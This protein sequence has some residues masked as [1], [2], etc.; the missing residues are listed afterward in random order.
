MSLLK[1]ITFVLVVVFW[2]GKEF[3][4]T[5]LN[6]IITYHTLGKYMRTTKV[7]GL[8]DLSFL[9]PPLPP[10]SLLPSLP[11]SLKRSLFYSVIPREKNIWK[12]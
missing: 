2:G 10:L 6:F 4:L 9:P 8:N 7:R 3:I 11:L 12:S 5:Y 1:L